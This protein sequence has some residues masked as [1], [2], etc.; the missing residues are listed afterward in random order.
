MRYQAGAWE[1]AFLW[2]CTIEAKCGGVLREVSSFLRLDPSDAIPFSAQDGKTLGGE[3][4]LVPLKNYFT[5]SYPRCLNCIVSAEPSSVA[6][7][8]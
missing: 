6:V 4:S 8:N 2:W 1:R 7:T 5:E 3:I